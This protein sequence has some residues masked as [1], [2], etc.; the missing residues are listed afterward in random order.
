M[1]EIWMMQPRF[2]RRHGQAPLR[3]LEHLRLRAG[4]DF[5]LLRCDC[6]EAPAELG[7]WWTQ[8]MA[9]DADERVAMSQQQQRTE[10][11]PA[12]RKRRRGGRRRANGAKSGGEGDSQS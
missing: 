1:R 6:G 3:L 4:Y 2:E 11:A 8:F 7:Q 9:A 5:L 10:G 12:A